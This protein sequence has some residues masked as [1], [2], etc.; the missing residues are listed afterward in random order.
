MTKIHQ[1]NRIGK[2][3][4]LRVGC[5]AVIFDHSHQKVLLTR[6]ADNGMWCLPSGAMD[7]GESAEEAC[8]REVWEETG[9]RAKVTR[10]VGIYTTP[11][12]AI[13]YPDGNRVQIVA[14]S[15]EAEIIGGKLGLSDETTAFGYYSPEEMTQLDMVPS[16]ARRVRDAFEGKVEAFVY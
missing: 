2:D 14:L 13:E 12:E 4:K 7:P 3:A 5:S 8:L 9:L 1:G 6:R 16:H 10:L 15:F 11:N